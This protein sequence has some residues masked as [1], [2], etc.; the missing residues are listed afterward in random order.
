MIGVDQ[1]FCPSHR[2][3]KFIPKAHH[4]LSC[5]ACLFIGLCWG[6][7]PQGCTLH[8][9]SYL[10]CSLFT[11]SPLLSFTFTT[12]SSLLYKIKSFSVSFCDA[13]RFLRLACSSCCNSLFEQ[14]FS[15]F[16]SWLVFIWWRTMGE[17]QK[18]GCAYRWTPFGRFS[19]PLN[20]SPLKPNKVWPTALGVL[21]WRREG[22]QSL[23]V[24]INLRTT[25]IALYDSGQGVFSE[26]PEMSWQS[27]VLHYD[28]YLK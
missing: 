21:G 15:L 10:S 11:S 2:S 27:E 25:D 19:S 14:S 4:A 1:Y 13:C 22:A 28:F 17:I 24:C 23:R 9:K 12:L 7:R 3:L 20:H 18:K 26:D 16:G 6:M 5:G 8:V